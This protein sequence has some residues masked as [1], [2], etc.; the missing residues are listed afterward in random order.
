[1]VH[2]AH[3]AV[4]ITRPKNCRSA[5]SLCVGVRGRLQDG[6]IISGL[7][8]AARYKLRTAP[9]LHKQF[10]SR[11][12]S[13]LNALSDATVLITRSV[14]WHMRIGNCVASSIAA[15]YQRVDLSTQ[16]QPILQNPPR[17]L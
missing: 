4:R 1:M 2:D 14:M 7:A 8:R 9:S 17:G 5:D 3:A 10:R 6:A 16:S 11:R 13:V 15:C 12:R